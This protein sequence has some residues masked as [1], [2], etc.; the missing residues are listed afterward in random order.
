MSGTIKG[1][2]HGVMTDDSGNL[3]VSFMVAGEN[4]PPARRRVAELKKHRE[5]GK[6][7]LKIEADIWREKRSLDANAY[8]HVICSKMAAVLNTSLDEVKQQLVLSYGTIKLYADGGIA[9]M[10]LPASIDVDEIYPYTK[11]YKEREENGILCNCYIIYKRTRELDSKEFSVL[12]DGTIS[13][14]RELGI[15]VATPEQITKMLSLMEN[16]K[17]S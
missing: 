15:E 12:L 16:R 2:L 17:S 6:D 3:I 9:V 8:F 11:W 4:I 7:T 14:A 5:N 13:E 10:K 1:S